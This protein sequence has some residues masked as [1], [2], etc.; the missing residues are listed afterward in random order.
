MSFE[1][2][3]VDKD[4]RLHMLKK[5]YRSSDRAYKMAGKVNGYVQIVWFV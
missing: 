1:V 3:Y 2:W 5:V 4:S